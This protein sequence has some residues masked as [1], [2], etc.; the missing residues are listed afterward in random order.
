LPYAVTYLG[1][2]IGETWYN[3]L[4]TKATKRFSHGLSVQASFVWSK[5]T[6]LGTGADFGYFDA[7]VPIP[8]D[9]YNYQNNKQ[10]NQL[11]RPLAWVISGE[12][13]ACH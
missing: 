5:A 12:V 10:L 3:T 9:M 2:P 8:G 1:P 4:Q 13:R 11:T 7:G 6:N